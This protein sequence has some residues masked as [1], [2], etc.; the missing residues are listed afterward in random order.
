MKIECEEAENVFNT[1]SKVICDPNETDSTKYNAFRIIKQSVLETDFVKKRIKDTFALFMYGILH[2]N[3]NIRNEAFNYFVDLDMGCSSYKT[4]DCKLKKEY[5][6]EAA[7]VLFHLRWL[8][9]EYEQTNAKN[10]PRSDRSTKTTMP[11]SYDTKDPFLKILRRFFERIETDHFHEM[12][13]KYG[14]IQAQN[15]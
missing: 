4:E 12:L 11:Y 5:Y 1:C 13:Q 3:G 10:L 6:E 14:I 7:K 15:S 2:E 9:G 8:H